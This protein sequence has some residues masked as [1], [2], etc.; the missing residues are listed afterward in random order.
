MIP[1]RSFA[2]RL[3]AAVALAGSLL[4]GDASVGATPAV[5]EAR[6]RVDEFMRGMLALEARGDRL[7]ELLGFTA[8]EAFHGSV[9]GGSQEEPGWDEIA[10]TSGAA[11]G[12]IDCEDVSD[13]K[14]E[15][16]VTVTLGPGFAFNREGHWPVAFEPR[17]YVVRVVPEGCR[18]VSRLPPP[19][20]SFDGALEFLGKPPFDRPGVLAL[21]RRIEGEVTAAPDVTAP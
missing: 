16:G 4:C 6:G 7:K 19:F 21:R 14:A 12:E 9:E 2:R 10:V 5:A 15:C 18:I 3:A 20:L 1:N 11:L 17:R 13:G 8:A